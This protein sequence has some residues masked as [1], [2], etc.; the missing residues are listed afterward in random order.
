[1]CI[2][3]VMNHGLR[4]GGG[5]GDILR[6]PSKDVSAPAPPPGPGQQGSP[7]SPMFRGASRPPSRPHPAVC[8]L[9][10][11]SYGVAVLRRGPTSPDQPSS[12]RWEP[13]SLQWML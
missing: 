10:P 8:P 5:V 3:T 13:S 1:M 12:L 9:L 4:N 6:K 11:G 7:V 2:V